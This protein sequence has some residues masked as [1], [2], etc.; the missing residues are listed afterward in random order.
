MAVGFMLLLFA[1]GLTSASCCFQCNSKVVEIFNKIRT[2]V[3][4]IQVRESRLRNR[5]DKLVKGMAE[6]FFKDYAVKHYTGRIEIHHFNTLIDHIQA[7]AE[8]FLHSQKTD[9]DFLDDLMIFRNETTL[10]FKRDLQIYRKKACSPTECGWLKMDVF[11][12]STCK[13]EKPSCLSPHICMG[14]FLKDHLPTRSSL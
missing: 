6:N 12:C 2:Q 1:I 3:I 10:M 5:C 13:T 11:S 9:Q 8:T 7:E 4:P 14:C